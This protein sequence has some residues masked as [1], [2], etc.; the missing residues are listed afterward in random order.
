MRIIHDVDSRASVVGGGGRPYGMRKDYEGLPYGFRVDELLISVPPTFDG[1]REE[2]IYL[3]GDAAY[4]LDALK[5]A[6]HV[7]ELSGA[8][9][10]ERGEL[11]E[12]WQDIK[13]RAEAWKA[14]K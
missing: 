14:K 11:A 6:V 8:F 1:E 2:T 7:L 9:L 12:D 4:L 13:K 3:S 5:Q 10:V